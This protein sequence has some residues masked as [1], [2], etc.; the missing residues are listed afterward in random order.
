MVKFLVKA[1]LTSILAVG[2]MNAYAI[3]IYASFDGCK[4]QLPYEMI[5]LRMDDELCQQHSYEDVKELYNFSCPNGKKYIFSM[6]QEL[7]L[8]YQHLRR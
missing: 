8:E 3:Q 2:S 5:K 4:E 7:C 1:G 6:K